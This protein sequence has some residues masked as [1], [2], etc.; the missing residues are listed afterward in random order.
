VNDYDVIVVEK[1]NVGGLARSALAK[2]VR[3]ASWGTFLSMLRYKAACAGSRVIE[4]DPDGTSQECSACGGRVP[5]ELKIRRHECSHCDL[6]IDRDLNAARNILNRAGVGPSLQN[7]AGCGRRAGGNLD[8][9]S[10]PQQA[11]R[12]TETLP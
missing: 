10:R 3:D 4:V 12:W 9:D 5:K 11:L 6:V 2:Q 1:L 8:N 7:V